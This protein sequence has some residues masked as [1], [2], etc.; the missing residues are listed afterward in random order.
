MTP[1]AMTPEPVSKVRPQPETLTPV[2]WRARLGRAMVAVDTLVIA[3][4]ILLAYLIRAELGDIGL[5]VPLRLELSVALGTLPL[6]LAILYMFGCYRPEYMNQGGEAFLRFLAG[7]VVALLMLGF[8]SFLFRLELARLWALVLTALVTVLGTLAR[9]IVR[10]YLRRQRAR[11]RYVQRV[12]IVGSDPEAQAVAAAM[13]IDPGLGYQVSGFV[14][15]DRA[16]GEWVMDDLRVIGGTGDVLAVARS[17]GAGLVLISPTGVPPGT[18]KDVTV[19]LEGSAVD[20]AVA[21]SLFEVMTHRMAVESV[22]NVA[23]LHVEQVRLIGWKAAIKRTVDLVGA[24]VLLVLAAPVMAVAAAGVKAQ[25]GG[26]VFFRQTRV[27]KDGRRFEMLKFRTMVQ[28]AEDRLQEVSSLNEAGHHFFK[29][30][31]DPR[32]TRVGRVLRKWSIDETPQLVQVI[33]GEMSLV[34]PRP[35]LPAEVARYEPWHLRRLRVRPGIT[36]VW[37]VS[38]RSN[39]P[40]DEAV[41]MDVFYIENWT[42]GYDLFLLAKTVVAVL[43]RRGAY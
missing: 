34:G 38:G 27:G 35:P 37:Q 26:P 39:I 30:R 12:V 43:G 33:R 42:L 29:I 41:R 9:A 25:D 15:D 40:F 22:A 13:R 23:I 17:H 1:Q 16:M 3:V 28:D 10:R 18:L 7:N 4:S 19:A 2:R 20:L 31:A 5:V 11:G 8:T 21:P 14:T 6:W 32:V 36:G 24:T